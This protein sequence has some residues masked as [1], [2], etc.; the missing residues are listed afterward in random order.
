MLTYSQLPAVPQ[1]CL[2]MFL[3]IYISSSLCSRYADLHFCVFVMCPFLQICRLWFTLR[4]QFSL[5]FK[6]SH[7]FSIYPAF[8]NYNDRSV[9]YE[10]FIVRC[11][12]KNPLNILSFERPNIFSIVQSTYISSKT[13]RKFYQHKC[14]T[15][16]FVLACS[17]LP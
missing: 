2:W 14:P 13:Y 17:N 12:T 11:E 3:P 15:G 6:K 7:W 4:L 16:T 9:D 8:K 10:L 5:G 1:N